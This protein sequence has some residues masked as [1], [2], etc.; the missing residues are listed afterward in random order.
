MVELLDE[1][2]TTFPVSPLRKVRRLTFKTERDILQLLDPSAD[3]KPGTG[4]K[5]NARSTP[6]HP[7][8]N[9]PV[10]PAPDPDDLMLT[11]D[12]GDESMDEA[13]AVRELVERDDP[14]GDDDDEDIMA[15]AT[16]P[17]LPTNDE[18]RAA[19]IIQHYYLAH[20][21]RCMAKPLSGLAEK[22]AQHFLLC[23]EKA[24]EFEWTHRRYKLLFLGAVPYVLVCLDVLYDGFI[25]DK[26]KAKRQLREGTHLDF[27]D[28]NC[29]MTKAK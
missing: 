27:E 13:N 14:N 22:R 1:S 25:A 6:F 15:E 4:F 9:L 29:R 8:V 7:K 12:D 24:N 28:V 11:T 10:S 19:K 17:I 23:L 18:I 3:T 20:V 2:K 26:N 21:R 16:P 5:L